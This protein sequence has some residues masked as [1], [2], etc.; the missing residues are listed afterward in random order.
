MLA[1][2]KQIIPQS[3]S[4]DT[5]IHLPSTGKLEIVGFIANELPVWRDRPDRPANVSGENELSGLLCAHLNSA[6]YTST[7]WSHLQFLPEMRDEAFG[8][9]K[10]DIS[11]NP[12]TDIKIEGRRYSCFEKL[13]P[14][15]CKR[16]PTPKEKGRDEREYVTNEPGTTG[17]IQR[18]K[19]GY[20]GSDHSFAAII[21]YVQ[22]QSF[23][24]WMTQVN[25]WISDL[26]AGISSA[27]SDSDLLQLVGENMDT[28][29][30]MLQSEHQR[31]KE[32]GK[33]ELRHLWISIS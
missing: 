27:W 26:A 5:D 24:Y 9:R 7:T 29:V 21:A 23:S 16:L 20:H 18:Y 8:N 12:L 32:S 33:I 19:F 25:R 31:K 1:D 3:G 17:G 2:Y 14:I 10:I 30:R 15:E 4:L 28:K 6:A 11:V 13:F 22:D